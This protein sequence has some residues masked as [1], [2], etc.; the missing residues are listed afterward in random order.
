MHELFVI[1]IYKLTAQFAEH[2]VRVEVA[3]REN[4][5]SEPLAAFVDLTI[6]PGLHEGVGR[7]QSCNASTN[8]DHG[9]VEFPM[10]VSPKPRTARKG[11]RSDGRHG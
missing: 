6:H 8:N 7:R 1:R 11:H 9:A 10:T 5:S 2:A 3:L 4:P